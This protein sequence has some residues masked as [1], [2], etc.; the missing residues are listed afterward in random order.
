MRLSS[1][2]LALIIPGL[3]IGIPAF[4]RKAPRR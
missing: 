3:L 2:D 4:A 1:A